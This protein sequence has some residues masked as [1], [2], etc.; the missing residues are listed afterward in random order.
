MDCKIGTVNE[1]KDHAIVVR[2]ERHTA[3]S[4]CHAKGA[5]TSA[6]RDEQMIE[7]EDYPLGTAVGDRVRIVPVEGGTP[8]KAVLYAFII[9][10]LIIIAVVIF[11]HYTGI[12]ETSMMLIQLGGLL[13]YAGILRLGRGY[14]DKTFRLRAEIVE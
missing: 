9:P 12:S 13:L 14:L 11:A 6:D 4:N 5:C 1:I 8:M 7:V 2:I 3:C 10:L